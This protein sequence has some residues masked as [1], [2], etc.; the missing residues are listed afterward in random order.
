MRTDIGYRRLLERFGGRRVD[1][2]A[3]AEVEEW[4]GELME[5]LSIATVNHHLQRF[6]FETRRSHTLVRFLAPAIGGSGMLDRSKRPSLIM[7]Q[8][9][10]RTGTD[11]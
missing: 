4:Q 1:S 11:N 5:S 2:I 6:G 8:E 7:E 3:P 10:M 9:L